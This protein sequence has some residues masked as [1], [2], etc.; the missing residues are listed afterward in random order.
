MKTEWR[1]CALRLTAL[2]LTAVMSGVHAADT[3]P[4]KSAASSAGCR[5]DGN[6][7]NSYPRCRQVS[8]MDYHYTSRLRGEPA[9][10]VNDIHFHTIESWSFRFNY[11]ANF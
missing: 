3:K 1:L 10:G 2:L 4:Q 8:A 6:C 7:L 11:V 9:A 5:I